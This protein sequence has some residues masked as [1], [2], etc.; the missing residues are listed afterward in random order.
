MQGSTLVGS[1]V[2]QRKKIQTKKKELTH[3]QPF[4]FNLLINT[5]KSNF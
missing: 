5:V 1:V 2:F 3:V 4:D